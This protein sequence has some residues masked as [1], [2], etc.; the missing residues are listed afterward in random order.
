MADEAT[1]APAT[2]APPTEETKTEQSV[3]YSRF[4]E[5]NDKAKQATQELQELKQRLQELED[6]DKSEIERERTQRERLQAELQEREAKL[7]QVERGSWVRDAAVEAKFIDPT[8]ALGRIDLSKIESASDAKR[9]VKKIAESAKHLIQSEAPPTPQIGQ[10]I[11]GGQPVDPNNLTP[12][13][14]AVLAQQKENE[15]F[16]NEL[17]AASEQGWKSTSVGLL[18]G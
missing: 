4:A 13:Q 12:Q 2:P 14:Q 18:D 6:R 15:E 16:L 11:A 10:V 9:E 1:P 5:V 8:D 7:V 17:K 3:P